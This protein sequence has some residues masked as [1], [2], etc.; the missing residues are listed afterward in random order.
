MSTNAQELLRQEL[1]QALLSRDT[2][3][4]LATR[5]FEIIT[6]QVKRLIEF[7][8]TPSTPIKKELPKCPT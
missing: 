1:K 5:R 4:D 7:K 2:W 3:R 8:K 6:E